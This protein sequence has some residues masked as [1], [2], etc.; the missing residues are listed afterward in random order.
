MHTDFVERHSASRGLAIAVAV[1]TSVSLAIGACGPSSSTNPAPSTVPSTIACR[2]PALTT[3]HSST[4]TPG[5][6]DLATGV[7]QPAA[8]VPAGSRY[9]PALGRWIS[10]PAPA[11]FRPDGEA[12]AYAA[13]QPRTAVTGPYA[14]AIV[15]VVDLKTGRDRALTSAGQW[16]IVGYTTEGI[17]LGRPVPPGGAWGLWRLDPET[18]A[19][20]QLAATYHWWPPHAGA[21]WAFRLNMSHTGSFA[22]EFQG[23]ANELIRLDLATGATSSWLYLPD[24]LTS[25]LAFDDHGHPI[26][27]AFSATMSH[28]LVVTAPNVARDLVSAPVGLDPE[29]AS[30]GTLQLFAALDTA[31]GIWL[32]WTDAVWLVDD[33][34]RRLVTTPLPPNSTFRLDTTWGCI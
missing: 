7:F 14:D 4:Q 10:V 27:N 21:A 3:D 24:E 29:N 17:Y 1:A 22:T 18:G 32:Q 8:E 13:E 15:H 25:Y 2:V 23:G 11:A 26:V 30:P 31:H 28:V 9:V 16:R 5:F 19:I 12:Y 6:M 33:A 34:G 20:R